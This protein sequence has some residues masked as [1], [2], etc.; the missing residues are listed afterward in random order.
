MSLRCL[1]RRHRPMLTSI[2]K[3]EGG[4]SALCNEC[5]LPIERGEEGRWVVAEP[6]LARRSEAA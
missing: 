6:L 3:R 1:F 4:Y 2:M 5:G